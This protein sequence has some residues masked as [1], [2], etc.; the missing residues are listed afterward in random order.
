MRLAIAMLAV[1]GD[2]WLLFLV[3]VRRTNKY[4]REIPELP[5]YR[6][7]LRRYPDQ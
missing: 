1:L 6:W 5:W 7:V 4:P 3:R 2:V